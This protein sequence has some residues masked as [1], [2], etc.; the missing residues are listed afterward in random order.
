MQELR[1]DE[2]YWVY[3]DLDKECGFGCYVGYAMGYP[4][5]YPRL[6]VGLYADAGAAGSEAARAA[7][8]RIFLLEGWQL[9]TE[10]TE[11]HEARRERNIASLLGE[12]DHVVA[13]K[14]F[15]IDSIRQLEEELTTF[16]KEHP[17]MPW[18]AECVRTAL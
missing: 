13:A 11:E 12:E 17:G 1:A 10:N 15:F 4:D 16:K 3:A 5:G 8:E 18:Q 14:T 9:D 6:Q 2:G 7:I